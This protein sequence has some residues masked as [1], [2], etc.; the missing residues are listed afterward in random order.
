MLMVAFMFKPWVN[1][2]V[3]VRVVPRVL[4]D[5]ILVA[6]HGTFHAQAFDTGFRTTLQYV[7]DIG[8]AIAP[9]KSY[10]ISTNRVTR[11]SLRL[12]Q[13]PQLGGETI[14]VRLHVRDLGTHICMR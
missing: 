4:A 7:H 2:I 6:A 12:I 10:L 1:M 5:D 3:S 13:W 14:P 9:D 11:K 8:A